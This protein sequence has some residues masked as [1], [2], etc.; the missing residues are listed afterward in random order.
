VPVLSMSR[1][2]AAKACALAS[3]IFGLAMM[4]PTSPAAQGRLAL[5]GAFDVARLSLLPVD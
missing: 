1:A 4:H 5:A 2:T 3:A